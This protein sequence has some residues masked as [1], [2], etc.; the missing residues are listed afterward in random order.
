[1]TSGPAGRDFPKRGLQ[2][3]MRIRCSGGW[4]YGFVFVWWVGG[5]VDG[6]GVVAELSWQGGGGVLSD[7]ECDK[8]KGI[9]AGTA[10]L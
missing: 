1:M 6:V 4:V 7:A 5:H 10:A 9:V 8:M 3:C 2:Q